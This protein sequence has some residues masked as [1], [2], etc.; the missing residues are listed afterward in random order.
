MQWNAKCSHHGRRQRSFRRAGEGTAALPA[1]EA[2]L[3][4]GMTRM[5]SEVYFGKD[6]FALHRTVAVSLPAPAAC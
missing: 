5:L 2:K 4:R 3:P 6:L 1:A